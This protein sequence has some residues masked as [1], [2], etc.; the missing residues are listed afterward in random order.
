MEQLRKEYND[1]FE[2]DKKKIE[3]EIKKVLYDTQAKEYVFDLNII[4]RN[5]R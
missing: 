4:Y 3:S 5:S 1:K 2:G